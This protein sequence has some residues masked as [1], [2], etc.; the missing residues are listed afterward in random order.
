MVIPIKGELSSSDISPLRIWSFIQSNISFRVMLVKS[1][2][3]AASVLVMAAVNTEENDP[4][5]ALA[6]ADVWARCMV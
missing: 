4:A 5:L 2:S 3:L 1:T 6:S